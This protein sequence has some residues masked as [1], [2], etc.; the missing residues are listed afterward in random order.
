M[1][2]S[3]E[4]L[5]SVRCALP[6]GVENIRHSLPDNA[7]LPRLASWNNSVKN[8]LGYEKKEMLGQSARIL[9]PG[10][11]VDQGTGEE[12]P[13]V[14]RQGQASDDRWIVRKEGLVPVYG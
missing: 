10:G 6:V 4:N 9:H 11:P 8:L 3:I 1:P 2:L 13:I 14:V 12:L 7:R 5:P